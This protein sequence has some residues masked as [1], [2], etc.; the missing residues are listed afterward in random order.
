MLL[1]SSGRG[2]FALAQDYSNETWFPEYDY[3]LG[4]PGSVI[5]SASSAVAVTDGAGSGSGSG[6][7]AAGTSPTR[8]WTANRC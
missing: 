3:D 2:Q 7:G 5:V 8:E 4:N 6:G 1:A